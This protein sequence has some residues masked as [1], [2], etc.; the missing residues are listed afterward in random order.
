MLEQCVKNTI[1]STALTSIFRYNTNSTAKHGTAYHGTGVSW[2]KCVFLYFSQF[3]GCVVAVQWPR[4][5]LP[6]AAHLGVPR[7]SDAAPSAAHLG[8]P[9]SSRVRICLIVFQSSGCLSLF[10]CSL[11]EAYLA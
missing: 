4:Y 10:R 11:M 1:T 7:S 6:P 3:L 9:R 2:L 8:V 5:V